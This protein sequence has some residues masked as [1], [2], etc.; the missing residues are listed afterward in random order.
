MPAD[1]YVSILPGF[2]EV[3]GFQVFQLVFDGFEFGIELQGEVE[4]SLGFP[5]LFFDHG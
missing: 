2:F 1:N 5:L 4:E 3:L